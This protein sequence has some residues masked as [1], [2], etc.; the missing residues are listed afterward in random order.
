[1]CVCVSEEAFS[2]IKVTAVME[3]QQGGGGERHLSVEQTMDKIY[4]FNAEVK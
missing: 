2:E 1:M 3:R 4:F